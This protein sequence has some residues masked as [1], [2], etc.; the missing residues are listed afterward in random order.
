MRCVAYHF[1]EGIAFLLLYTKRTNLFSTRD[2]IHTPMPHM[3]HA[4]VR[5]LA[6]VH[7]AI[8]YETHFL[9]A[10]FG[11]DADADINAFTAVPGTPIWGAR[12]ARSFATATIYKQ[13]TQT[14]SSR[15]ARTRRHTT[16]S[17]AKSGFLFQTQNKIAEAV[18]VPLPQRLARKRREHRLHVPRELV[19]ERAHLV[20]T[21]ARGVIAPSTN[22]GS[23]TRVGCR[24]SLSSSYPKRAGSASN[25]ICSHSSTGIAC[26]TRVW[27]SLYMRVNA[28]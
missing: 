6:W 14:S 2:L 19:P 12:T 3:N 16:S 10:L 1:F 22:G 4:T 7:H 9:L 5:E 27:S 24:S 25:S 17:C 21:C 8:P 20:C 26:H 13:K 18:R 28:A 11:D 23:L 15:R